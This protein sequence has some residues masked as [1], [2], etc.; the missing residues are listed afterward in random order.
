MTARHAAAE[1]GRITKAETQEK[2]RLWRSR[3]RHDTK[4]LFRWLREKPVPAAHSVYDDEVSCQDPATAQNTEVLQK[5]ST[6]WSRLWSRPQGAEEMEPETYLREYGPPPQ[7]A[8]VW[9]PVGSADLKQAARKQ[10]GKAAGPCG[11]TG[12]EISVWPQA[13][14]DD[15]AEVFQAWVTKGCFPETWS[16]INQV[17]LAKPGKA[18]EADGAVAISKLRPISLLS[19]FWRT[20]MSARLSTQE[21]QAWLEI[22]LHRSQAGGRKSRD[23][24]STFV[25]LAEAFA[26]SFYISS[27]DL[28]KA[29]DH[30][31]PQRA[32]S[33]LRWYGFPTNLANAVSRIWGRQLRYL[34]WNG[35]T[36]ARPHRVAS[37]IPQGDAL[38]PAVMNLILACPCSFVQRLIPSTALKVFLDDRSWGSRTLAE[39]KEV[40]DCWQA[41]S[42]FLGLRENQ[43]KKQFT[44][45]TEAGRREL[46]AVPEFQGHVNKFLHA[47][48][49]SLG[50]GK[51]ND[52]EL[53]RVAK[54][55]KVADR[56]RAAPNKAAQRAMAATMAV[57]TKALWMVIKAPC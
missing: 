38:S 9:N 40:Y 26:R 27:L 47:L 18:R 37:S 16:E 2:L 11:W 50:A 8:Q 44:H 33:T 6:F 17:H 49:A 22:H 32:D 15:L 36:L 5:V 24:Q 35:E 28:S 30:V 56:L 53:E 43:D 4:E 3:L 7:E 52:K 48:G 41:H 34:S 57:T 54:A 55:A 13:L 10:R 12:T 23:A 45:K 25:E 19:A 31:T 51:A 21:A 39:C 46:E 42:K 14:W 20:F 1:V 29:F